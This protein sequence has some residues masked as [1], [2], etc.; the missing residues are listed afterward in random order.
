L[1]ARSLNPRRRRPDAHNHLL[2]KAG[3]IEPKYRRAERQI[4]RQQDEWTI[5]ELAEE[6]GV[7]ESTVYGWVQK[8]RLRYRFVKARFGRPAKLVH[9]DAATIA[10]LKAARAT[11]APW[12]RLPPPFAKPINSTTES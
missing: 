5:R 1:H 3:V 8:G 6:I 4:A 2:L 7:P 10:A 9:A 12:R 11:P